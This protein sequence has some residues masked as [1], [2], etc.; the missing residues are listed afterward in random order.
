MQIRLG[1]PKRDA[2][3]F[4]LLSIDK[5]VPAFEARDVLVRG[6]NHVAELPNTLFDPLRDT[7][8]NPGSSEH[9]SPLSHSV[10]SGVF[11]L[12]HWVSQKITAAPP[13]SAVASL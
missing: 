9:G 12:F 6:Y 2:D 4:S 3:Q 5:H 7:V 1:G 11:R 10:F 8:C 13:P